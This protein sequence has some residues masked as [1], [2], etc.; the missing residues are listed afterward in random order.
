MRELWSNQNTFFSH[1]KCFFKYVLLFHIYNYLSSVVIIEVI[2]I[3]FCVPIKNDRSTY[4][5]EKGA[6]DKARWHWIRAWERKTVSHF[7]PPCKRS[8]R[9]K[10]TVLT[11]R[12]FLA[13][14]NKISTSSARSLEC[15]WYVQF[16]SNGNNS[17]SHF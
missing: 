1:S 17:T 14:P 12:Q 6:L 15:I 13:F 4:S 7:S 5:L 11:I 10:K 8:R 16:G 9:T 2:K 3:N